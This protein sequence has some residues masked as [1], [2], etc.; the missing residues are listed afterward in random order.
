MFH[1][2]NLVKLLTTYQYSSRY[3]SDECENTIC[4]W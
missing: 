1:K 4:I 3:A 2:K